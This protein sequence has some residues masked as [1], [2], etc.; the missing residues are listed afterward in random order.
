MLR[1]EYGRCQSSGV[2]AEACAAHSTLESERY[3]E[4]V[5]K[6]GHITNL[7]NSFQHGAKYASTN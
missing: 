2:G 3:V 7:F 4:L 5:C 1:S 6:V